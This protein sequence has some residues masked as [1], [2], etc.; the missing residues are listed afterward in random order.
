MPDTREFVADDIHPP[1]F[2]GSGA[3]DEKT[4]SLS[5]SEKARIS[6]ENLTISP[7]IPVD[8]LVWHDQTCRIDLAE[9]MEPG[10]EYSIEATARDEKGNSLTFLTHIYGYN[11]AVPEIRLNEIT[12]QGSSSNPDKV[13]LKVLSAGNTAGLALYEGVDTSYTY[14]KILPPIEV[15]K[16]DYIVVHFKP[17]G[18]PEET[19]EISDPSS[20][21]AEESIAGSWDLWIEGGGGISGNNGVIALYRSTTGPLIDGFLYSNRTSSSDENYRG[22][23]TT[24]ALERAD[25]LIEQNGWK[26]EERL[27]APEDAVDP[28]DSTATRSICR[29]PD[30]EDSDSAEDWHIVPT[31]GSTFGKVNNTEVYVP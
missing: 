29:M 21:T 2:I 1:I 10:A 23:G 14:R 12:T 20:C 8:S 16:G 6:T 15:K 26:C 27:P 5:F 28:E 7:D 4:F 13:E 24:R 19:D 3:V 30:G 31:R 18:V 11:P 25:R 9:A 17:K 22:F